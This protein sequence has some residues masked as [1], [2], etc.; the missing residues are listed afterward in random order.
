MPTTTTSDASPIPS[1]PLHSLST[2][3]ADAVAA[4]APSVIHVR[5]GRGGGTGL[6]IADDLVVTSSF[7]AADDAEL[8]VPGGDGELATRPA[9]LV[10]RDP[11]TDLALFRVPGGGLT[12][13]RLRELDGVRVGQLALALGRPGRSVRASLRA[14][15]VLGPALRTPWGGQLDRY[16]ETDRALPRGFAGGPLVDASGAVLGLGTR[17]LIRGADLAVP[18]A[19][20][21]RVVAEL[22]AHGGVRHGYLGVSAYPVTVDD[23]AGALIASVD[24]AGPAAAA[25][26]LVGD[27]ILRLAGAPTRGPD[28]LRAALWDRPGAEVEIAL[29]RAGQPLTVTVAL[30]ARTLRDRLGASR[31]G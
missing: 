23:E 4:A 12:P 13:A 6:A 10:G 2:A 31:R 14:I 21:R 26:L 25:G 8:G 15:G 22:L 7:H 1:E 19:T 5:R 18:T 30:G 11:G 17:T 20:I 28:G 29:R 9:E 27:V 3:L 24:A 16:V